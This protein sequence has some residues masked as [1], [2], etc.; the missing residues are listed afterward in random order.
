M[1]NKG[2]RSRGTGAQTLREMCSL[3]HPI[4]V[5]LP[6]YP[7]IHRT[8]DCFKCPGLGCYYFSSSCKKASW[9]IN[10]CS[11]IWNTMWPFPTPSRQLCLPASQ[12]C[13]E[14]PLNNNME[15]PSAYRLPEL[16]QKLV[17]RGW[18]SGRLCNY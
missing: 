9:Y 1:V 2:Q 12:V 13:L 6:T 7:I 3:R 17:W 4:S 5:V 11:V 15:L 14:I 10:R 8:A 18:G 16:I